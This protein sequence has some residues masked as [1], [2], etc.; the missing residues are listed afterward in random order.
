MHTPST[1]GRRSLDAFI[2]P[3]GGNT[4]NIQSFALDKLHLTAVAIAAV[5]RLADRSAV[6]ALNLH[7]ER[8]RPAVR[9]RHLIRVDGRLRQRAQAS[10][11]LYSAPDVLTCSRA[12]DPSTPSR[13]LDASDPRALI[14]ILSFLYF[15]TTRPFLYIT[16]A[17]VRPRVVLFF[18]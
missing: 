2:N 4:N 5:S 16:L 12:A 18:P 11:L 15:Y 17:S 7:S 13:P 9:T 3:E 10:P 6:R 8:A 14:I 1:Q